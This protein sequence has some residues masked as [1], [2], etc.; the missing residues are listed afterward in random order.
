MNDNARDA[1]VDRSI[2]ASAVRD[3]PSP[4]ARHRDNELWADA[5]PDHVPLSTMI[6]EPS[7]DAAWTEGVLA[8]T[9][10]VAAWWSTSRE[11]RRWMAPLGFG[12]V[13]LAAAVGM[14]RLGGV[15]ELLGTHLALG[16]LATGLGVPLAGAGIVA[17]SLGSR[18]RRRMQQAAAFIGIL[19]ALVLL[20]TDG[21]VQRLVR[22]IVPAALMLLTIGFSFRRRS[23]DGVLGPF[24]V[25]VAGL[26][27][28]G[29]GQWLGFERGGWFHLAM[30]VAIAM[31]GR[32]A[33]Q[34]PRVD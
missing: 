19:L 25:I 31:L 6:L 34:P 17:G 32:A 15:Q 22:L 3:L 4:V 20:P 7:W 1:P 24:L 10:G 8:A 18:P 33:H 21:V 28:F 12:L 16:R 5:S 26:V 14:F 27:I 9:A 2:V 30:A 11:H 29:E 23:P 13:G